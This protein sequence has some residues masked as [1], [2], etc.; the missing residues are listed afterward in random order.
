MGWIAWKRIQNRGVSS[1]SR[2]ITVALVVL[3]LILGAAVV[4]FADA[5]ATHTDTNS[6]TISSL[7]SSV[8]S[9]RGTNSLLQSQ[10]A[11]LSG[12]T[13]GNVSVSGSID[14]EHIYAVDNASVVTI[15]GE[16]L[17]TGS[18]LFG[19]GTAVETVLGSGFVISYSNQYYIVTNNHVVDGVSN[20]TVT[21]SDGDSYPLKVVGT[22]PYSDLSVVTAPSA[23][24]GE[25]VPLQL[26]S[27]DGVLVGQPV[28][29]IGN[30]YGLSGSITF[31]IVSQLGRTIEEATT[32]GFSI[33]DIIQFSAPINP[34]NSG[35]PLLNENGDVLGIT[36]ATVNGSEGI[37]FA[38]PSST[39]LKELPSLISTGAYDEHAYLGIETTDMN[40][41]LAQDSG[42]NVT[43]GVLVEEVVSGGPAAKAGLKAGT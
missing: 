1:G 8:S 38:I 32:N 5:T 16:E 3:V 35:G 6:A 41:Q 23:P 12:A 2:R 10:L 13:T 39:I 14:A 19:T 26:I 15:Q 18:G 17:V 7:Q 33:S 22:D 36:T 25:F 34:G 29:V 28:V 24:T 43:Y 30:P 31:G 9:L 37:G 11:A 4:Y 21:F 42:T 40:Y 20:M 27:S